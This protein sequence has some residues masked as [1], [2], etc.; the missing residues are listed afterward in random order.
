MNYGAGLSFIRKDIYFLSGVLNL[1]DVSSDDSVAV[2]LDV[3][4]YINRF[5]DIYTEHNIP[6]LSQCALVNTTDLGNYC[7]YIFIKLNT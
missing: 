1:K 5:H 2:Y 4:Y 7:P 6:T 3:S